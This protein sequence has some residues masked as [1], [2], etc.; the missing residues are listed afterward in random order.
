MTFNVAPGYFHNVSQ[1]AKLM[2]MAKREV[3]RQKD[4]QQVSIM[5]VYCMYVNKGK[6][7]SLASRGCYVLMV[8]TGGSSVEF[9]VDFIRCLTK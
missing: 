1:L 8:G 3:K 6:A 4:F 2:G 9:V 5:V 7:L